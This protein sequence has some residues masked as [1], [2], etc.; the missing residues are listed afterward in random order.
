MRRTLLATLALALAASCND[1]LTTSAFSDLPARFSYQPVSSMSQLYT[2]CNSPGEWCTITLSNNKYLFTNLTGTGEALRTALSGYTGFYMGLSG[3]IVGLPNIPEMGY[4]TS[5]VTCYELAC[6]NCYHERYVAKPLTLLAGGYA[7]CSACDLTYNLNNLGI[8][9]D[10]GG[11][12]FSYASPRPLYR[13]RVYYGND[14][15]TINNNS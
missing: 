5:I 10:T 14:I 13:Y 15:L 3:F 6:S 11:N 12:T 4:D 2:S 9:S 1:A 8:V 7:H